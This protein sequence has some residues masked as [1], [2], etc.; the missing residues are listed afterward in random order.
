MGIGQRVVSFGSYLAGWCCHRLARPACRA[1]FMPGM[2]AHFPVI[3]WRWLVSA[4]CPARRVDGRGAGSCDK[5]AWRR[6]QHYDLALC[7]ARWVDFRRAKPWDKWTAWTVCPTRGVDVRWAQSCDN[8]AGW[9][10]RGLGCSSA[11]AFCW[12]AWPQFSTKLS[13][14]AGV[15]FSSLNVGEKVV[16]PTLSRHSFVGGV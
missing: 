3:C 12:V 13:H 4:V 2:L 14:F 9:G 15:A 1:L 11:W 5:P 7:P 8:W 10:P 16:S 6:L